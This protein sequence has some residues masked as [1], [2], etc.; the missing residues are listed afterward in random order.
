MNRALLVGRLVKDIDL[1]HPENNKAIGN[2]TIALNREYKN[3][4]GN[5]ETD[6]INIVLFG[7]QAENLSKYSQKGDLIGISGKIQT[8]NYLLFLLKILHYFY[9]KN[10]LIHF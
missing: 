6:F 3:A 2:T 1:R 5:Y 8:R 7:I 9:H 10:V 4:A